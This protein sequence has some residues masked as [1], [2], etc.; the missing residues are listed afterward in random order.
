MDSVDARRAIDKASVF[1]TPYPPQH[2]LRKR[3]LLDAHFGKRQPGAGPGSARLAL[4][5][6]WR[7]LNT[8]YVVPGISCHRPLWNAFGLL[9]ATNASA[10]VAASFCSIA[11]AA[12]GGSVQNDAAS[13][14]SAT[15]R[16]RAIRA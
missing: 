1:R 3:R 9:M 2:T 16:T 4:F 11:A 10:P 6:E 15:M 5:V 14:T 12:P 7:R 13:T 8:L